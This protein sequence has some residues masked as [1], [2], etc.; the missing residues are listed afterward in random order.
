[1]ERYRSGHNEPHSKCGHRVT[2][3]WVRIPLSP[4]AIRLSCRMAFFFPKTLCSTKSSTKFISKPFRLLF[5]LS[6][7]FVLFQIKNL[8]HCPCCIFLCIIFKMRISV[9][10]RTEFAM[11]QPFLN[12]FHRYAGSH[13]HRCDTVMVPFSESMAD[14]LSLWIQTLSIIIHS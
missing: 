7:Y 3:A 13:K 2:G 8:L 4:L 11:S 14:H 6:L 9:S 10:R 5:A 1:M 12:L